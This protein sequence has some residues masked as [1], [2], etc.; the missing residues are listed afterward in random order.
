[1]SNALI[2]DFIYGLLVWNCK[3]SLLQYHNLLTGLANAT[4]GNHILDYSFV[5]CDHG[6]VVRLVD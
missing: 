5:F 3:V 2:G 4:M 1:M 6:I